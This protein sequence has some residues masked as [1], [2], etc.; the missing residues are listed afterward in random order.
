MPTWHRPWRWPVW[1]RPM[2]WTPRAWRSQPATGTCRAAS[3]ARTTAFAR[4]SR[5]PCRGRSAA[6]S[7]WAWR[8]AARAISWPLRCHPRRRHLGW[9]RSRSRSMPLRRRSPMAATPCCWRTGRAW[10]SWAPSPLGA[11]ARWPR[12][13]P[14]CAAACRA[15]SSM[16][17]TRW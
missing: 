15:C 10:S 5:P 7:A 12:C 16:A 8:P 9:W 11:T 6:S 13:R 14:R 1:T 3:S 4:I 17:T 2:W